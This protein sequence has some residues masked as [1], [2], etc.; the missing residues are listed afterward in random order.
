MT[1][2]R[3]YVAAAFEYATAK[4][5]VAGWEAMLD[6]AANVASNT[7]VAALMQNPQFDTQELVKFFSDI[8]KPVL[9]PHKINF[10]RLLAEKNRLQALPDIAAMFKQVRAE[11]EKVISVQV[12][13]ATPLP[14]A[15]QQK[16]AQALTKR[17]QRTVE[18]VCDIDPDVLGGVVIRAGDLVIDGSIRGKLTRLNNFI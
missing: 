18:L 13:S 4:K 11:D 16:L 5:D 14:M 1:I 7:D 2:A 3:P 9:D 12:S 15:Y 6:A 17:L 8:L 10:I